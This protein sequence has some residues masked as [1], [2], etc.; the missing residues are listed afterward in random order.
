MIKSLFGGKG[1]RSEA[2]ASAAQKKVDSL[3]PENGERIS[4]AAIHAEFDAM[5]QSVKIDNS[6]R[7]AI[8]SI[9]RPSS[10]G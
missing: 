9:T 1:G 2:N 6:N 5:A 4:L 10:E 3:V 7:K 8:L